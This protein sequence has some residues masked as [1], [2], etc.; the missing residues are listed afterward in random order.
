MEGTSLYI[1]PTWNGI[2]EDYMNALSSLERK[3]ILKSY[4]EESLLQ[5]TRKMYES[6]SGKLSRYTFD[7]SD[8]GYVTPQ[9]LNASNDD[10]SDTDSKCNMQQNDHY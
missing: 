7:K 5:S 8:S 2:S 9:A 1:T 4:I 6:V 10:H 3:K